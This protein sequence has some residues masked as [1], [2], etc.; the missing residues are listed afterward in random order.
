MHL[1][2][3]I[4]T[5]HFSPFS[6]L[7]EYCNS[8]LDIMA[9]LRSQ[10]TPKAAAPPRAATP[11]NPRKK[12]KIVP[13]SI[14]PDGG[15]TGEIDETQTTAE[16]VQQNATPMFIASSGKN[17]RVT[18]PTAPHLASVLSANVTPQS[19]S[20]SATPSPKHPALDVLQRVFQTQLQPGE[21]ARY[22]VMISI[23]VRRGAKEARIRQRYHPALKDFFEEHPQ[24]VGVHNKFARKYNKQFE[25][26]HERFHLPVYKD[27][28]TA[29]EGKENEIPGQETPT[30]PQEQS[31]VYGESRLT[32][33]SPDAELPLQLDGAM[34]SM[35]G[36]KV[37]PSRVECRNLPLLAT[38]SR[39]AH[40]E[41][42]RG[43]DIERQAHH[44]DDVEIQDADAEMVAHEAVQEYGIQKGSAQD[45]VWRH[46]WADE[47]IQGIEDSMI[48]RQQPAQ[49]ATSVTTHHDS[50]PPQA[51]CGVSE[52]GMI[53][54]QV[55]GALGRNH[56]RAADVVVDG[57][58]TE[59][60]KENEERD[61]EDRNKQLQPTRSATIVGSRTSTTLAPIFH[62]PI[63]GSVRS[64]LAWLHHRQ[65]RFPTVAPNSSECVLI[66]NN[67]GR[68]PAIVYDEVLYHWGFETDSNWGEWYKQNRLKVLGEDPRFDE[69]VMGRWQA[70]LKEGRALKER[71]RL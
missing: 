7:Y 61:S 22:E 62:F 39:S 46:T 10:E 15:A 32:T 67:V 60:E 45:T 55:D 4:T 70:W 35:P 16:S 2:L 31:M 26:L 6:P 53:S 28:N 24:A 63:A 58:G 52:V 23:L 49:E 14:K 29:K 65:T 64:Y 43:L 66:A 9:R 42:G 18:T 48:P 21:Y 30:S 51:V 38:I 1:G 68:H 33:M 3:S 54:S 40:T 47:P 11:K 56:V 50:T 8:E 34:D 69:E 36:T 25:G 59:N 13:F 27:L 5:T 57:C 41:D 12:K 44:N 37:R 71:R 19:E 17:T 20:A